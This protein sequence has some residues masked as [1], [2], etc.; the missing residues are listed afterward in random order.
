[1]TQRRT[2]WSLFTL[3]WVTGAACDGA[4]LLAHA[5]NGVRIHSPV[6]KPNVVWQRDDESHAQCVALMQDGT[7]T[8]TTITE[9][10]EPANTAEA[11][12][13]PSPSK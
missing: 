4:G 10:V 11:S 3:A 2:W 7:V 6:A 12:V 9:L 8:S 1:M 13:S 5:Y